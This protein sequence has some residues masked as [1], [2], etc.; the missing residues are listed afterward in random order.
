MI[1]LTFLK[2][3]SKRIDD[4]VNFIKKHLVFI[5][6]N[7]TNCT[8]AIFEKIK[9]FLKLTRKQIS[10]N[11]INSTK[12]IFDNIK[13]FLKLTEKQIIFIFTNIMNCTKVIFEKIKKFFKSELFFS[14]AKHFILITNNLFMVIVVF[15]VISYGL[16]GGIFW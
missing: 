9:E 14:I 4:F 15:P 11:V 7:I 13:G 8:K 12:I 10:T 5:Y 3:I 6:T 16:F 2:T 1:M